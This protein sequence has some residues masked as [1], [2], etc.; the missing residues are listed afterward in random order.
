MLNAELLAQ[1]HKAVPRYT[2]YP[3]A[4]D[5]V[6]L[7]ADD[8][9]KALSQVDTP[10]SLYL[11]IPFCER[12]CLYCGCSVILNRKSENEVRYV[13]SLTD[14][15]DL[16]T[17]VLGRKKRVTQIHLGGGTPTKLSEALLIKVMQKLEDCFE[18]DFS[19][20]IAIEVDPRTV[21]ADRGAKLRLL[22]KLGFNRISFGVQDSDP[23]VQEAVKRHQSW[24][25]T[26]ST[27][28]LARELGFSTINLDLI[29]GLPFQTE[30]S[31]RTTIQQIITLKADR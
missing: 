20:E 15:I 9:L 1:L 31:F 25:M 29:Y 7:T 10:L 16:V 30:S 17:R 4:V 26:K 22:K 23:K 27:Y 8:Y 21:F 14:E 18:I 11:H 13:E 3:T 5:W 24:D 2:S 28:F 19:R 6:P 12:M